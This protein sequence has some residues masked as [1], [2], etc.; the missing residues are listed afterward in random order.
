MNG[1][2]YGS[3]TNLRDYPGRTRDLVVGIR[4]LQ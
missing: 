3:S 2:F 1:G 4:S